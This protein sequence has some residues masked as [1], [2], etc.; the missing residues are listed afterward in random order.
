MSYAPKSSS[1][2]KE[3]PCRLAS[4]ISSAQGRVVWHL[5]RAA[6]RFVITGR[7]SETVLEDFCFVGICIARNC[8]IEFTGQINECLGPFL[9]LRHCVWYITVAREQSLGEIVLE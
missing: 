6:A 8:K 3:Q 9:W 1:A 7:L 2:E 4:T 5:R